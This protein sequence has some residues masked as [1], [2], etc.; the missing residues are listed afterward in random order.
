MNFQENYS[1]IYSAWIGKLIGIRLGAPVEAWTYDEIQ[2]VM[3]DIKNYVVDYGIFAADDDSNGPLFFKEVFR[4]LNGE[5]VTPKAIANTM[6]NYI[7]Y[8]HGFF[9]W[10]GKGISTE[11]TAYLNLMD[12]IQP[13]HSGSTELNG[14]VMA[15][16]IGGQI[17]VD[18]CGYCSLGNPDLAKKWASMASSITH[19]GDGIQGGIFVAVMIALSFHYND[20]YT[21]VQKALTTLDQDAHYTHVVKDI[22][23]Y[24]DEH[25]SDEMACFDYILSKYSYQHYPGMCH[26][27][28]NIAIMVLA[29]LYGRNDFTKTM[30]LLCTL[31]YDTDCNCGNVG[32]ILGAITGVENIDEKWIT[33]LQDLLLASSNNGYMNQTTIS[34][35]AYEFCVC[36]YLANGL[37][38]PE[39]FKRDT[40]QQHFIFDL[41]YATKGFMTN[42][43]RYRES[44]VCQRDG[45]LH[46]RLNNCRQD[47]ILTLYKYTYFQPNDIYDARYEPL[48]APT[49]FPG[50]TITFEVKNPLNVDCS[51]SLY[52]RYIDG[53]S[54]NSTW[55]SGTTQTL[56]HKIQDTTKCVHQIGLQILFNEQVLRKYLV[57]SRVSIDRALSIDYSLKS[58]TVQDFGYTFG[59]TPCVRPT[60]FSHHRGD[61]A[62]DSTGFHLLS[63]DEVFVQ[64]GDPYLKEYTLQLNL[65]LDENIATY[66][67][68][69]SSGYMDFK[70]LQCQLNEPLKLVSKHNQELQEI[71]TSSVIITNKNLSLKLK[72]SY[73]LIR[74]TLENETV[75]FLIE[76]A[77]PIWNQFGIYLKGKGKCTLLDCKL[78]SQFSI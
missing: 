72:V 11:H 60:F 33:P 22:V 68:F 15:E 21:I 62:Y 45:E 17:F 39:E 42:S 77:P 14:Q 30:T 65:Q 47:E 55:V 50:E 76:D 18:W 9:W 7:P 67:C 32:S 12:G 70:A 8:E 3:G 69:H 78:D 43:D 27:I 2:A 19:D 66:V 51:L 29:L 4:N 31:G 54:E 6:L 25:P 59:G 58:H 73:D 37:D 52:V 26:I 44:S 63:E 1:K 53:T 20:T 56:Q 74:I 28:P 38:I 40:T 24:F 23:T 46:V 48:F 34:D 5:Q 71:A 61:F 10:G 35:S 41:P 36:A 75:S 13:P 57:I 49:V 64:A 16:Q